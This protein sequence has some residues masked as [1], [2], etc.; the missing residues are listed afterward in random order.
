MCKDILDW[1]HVFLDTSFIIDYLSDASRFE[2]NPVKK[3]NIEVARM[4]MEFLSLRGKG[5]CFY[6]S[7]ITIGELRR[8]ETSSI[9]NEVIDM[10]SVGDVVFVSY[11]KEEALEVNR[12][13]EDYKRSMAPRLALKDLHKARQESGC[14]HYR[15]WISDDMKI[16]SCAKILH[17]R[18]Q[19][20]VILTS[21]EKT[22][23][24][25]ARFMNLPCKVLNKNHF[26]P[27]AFGKIS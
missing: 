5:V 21:D 27:D 17:D 20:D 15:E 23:F 26:W 4:I 16:L 13:I 9:F 1:R 12:I 24:P 6:V 11:R 19:L 3:E 18:K 8:L 2:D 7:S 25:I 22:F 14:I 10:L